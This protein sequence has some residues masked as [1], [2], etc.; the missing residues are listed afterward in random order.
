MNAYCRTASALGV[1]FAYEAP[2]VHLELDGGRTTRV[3][4]EIEGRSKSLFPRS[5][6][7]ASG[8]FQGDIDWMAQAWGPAA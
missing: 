8:G 1:R 2:V 7:A 3:D 6:V 4:A 5:V